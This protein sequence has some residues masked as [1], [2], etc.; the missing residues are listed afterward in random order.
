MKLV[1]CPIDIPIEVTKLPEIRQHSADVFNFWDNE[2]LLDEN[3]NWRA[4]LHP[5]TDEI[6][7]IIKQLPLKKIQ[8]IRISKQFGPVPEHRDIYPKQVPAEDYKSWEEN[9]PCGYRIVLSGSTDALEV[10]ANKKW[11]TCYLPRIPCCYVCDTTGTMHRVADDPN[12]L[13]VY[14]RGLVDAEKHQALIKKSLKRYSD[15]AIYKL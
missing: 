1:F 10:C 12:R 6:V 13:I 11:Q 8:H 3:G 9:E 14:I 15:Y 7:N 4:D 5:D 2:Y